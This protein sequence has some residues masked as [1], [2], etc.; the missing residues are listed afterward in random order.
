MRNFLSLLK[1]EFKLFWQNKV[2]RILFIG[3]PILYGVLLG[4]VY[5][6]GKVTDLPII[7]VDQ[8]RT[9]MVRR[10]SKCL[11]IM[12]LFRLLQYYTTKITFRTLP[13]KKKQIVS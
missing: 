12:K 4:Y 6:K 7:I 13:S 1:R 3:A 9:E 8:D 5:G 2:L 11:T 10:S